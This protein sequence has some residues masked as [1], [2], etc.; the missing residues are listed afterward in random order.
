MDWDKTKVWSEGG[1]YARIF[2]NVEGREPQG[3]IPRSQ[4]EA[5]ADEMRSRLEALTDDRGR[6]MRTK[7]LRPRE[8][9]RQ[10]RNVAPD[11]IVHFDDLYW[12][13]IG[14]LG[15]PSLH[16]QENDT[17]GAGR[18]LVAEVAGDPSGPC[19]GN[20]E[21]DL[22][23]GDPSARSPQPTWDTNSRRYC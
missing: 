5:F 4:Y 19:L 15:Y 3:V 20:G 10:V 23:P 17:G 22:L 18:G 13:S 11:L 7:V 21:E 14:G 6:T 2:F 16:L 12:R 8:I 1:Y 9:Y